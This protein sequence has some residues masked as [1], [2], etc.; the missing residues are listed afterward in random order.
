M[1]E[2]VQDQYSRIGIVTT[3]REPLTC[4]PGKR[5]SSQASGVWLF[6]PLNDTSASPTN[7][8]ARLEPNIGWYELQFQQI[9][10]RYNRFVSEI[11]HRNVMPKTRP[12]IPRNR[13]NGGEPRFD[14]LTRDVRRYLMKGSYDRY[15]LPNELVG[16]MR[17]NHLTSLLNL[18]F[19]INLLSDRNCMHRSS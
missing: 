15:S 10:Y 1:V 19:A 11:R 4:Q 17:T 16:G 6:L 5:R 8:T 3:G 14:Y 9:P 12:D 13:E 18:T 2:E 7:P